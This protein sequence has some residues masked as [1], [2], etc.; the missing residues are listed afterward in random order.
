[1][2]V[3][4][5]EDADAKTNASLDMETQLNKLFETKGYETTTIEIKKG[6][7]ASCTGCFGCWTK[8]PGEC[9][10]NDL[11]KVIHKNYL[12]SDKVVFLTPVVFGQYGANIK[13]VLDRLLANALP[14]VKLVNGHSV[15][16]RRYEKYPEEIMIGY[17]NDISPDE[18]E[19]FL[20]MIAQYRKQVKLAFVIRKQDETKKIIEQISKAI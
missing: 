11:M 8:T 16:P 17:N 18:K 10:S 15:H 20:D 9:V 1:M 12:S 6:A 14:F 19:T 2:K 7:L 13:D 4:F 3:L 5:I